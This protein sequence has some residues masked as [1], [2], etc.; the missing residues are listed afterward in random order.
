MKE[1]IKWANPQQMFLLFGNYLFNISFEVLLVLHL[2]KGTFNKRLSPCVIGRI[3]LVLSVI[4]YQLQTQLSTGGAV[5]LQTTSKKQK[6][7]GMITLCPLLNCYS[8]FNPHINDNKLL[9]SF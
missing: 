4:M 1:C 3:S 2:V 6:G 8:L 5:P 7:P 9:S